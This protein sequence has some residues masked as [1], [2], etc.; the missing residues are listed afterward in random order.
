M[1]T[2]SLWLVAA[3]HAAPRQFRG[4]FATSQAAK[5]LGVI[6][7]QNA[8]NAAATFGPKTKAR[9]LASRAGILSH[10]SGSAMSA[11]TEQDTATRIKKSATL[12]CS[13]IT[14]TGLI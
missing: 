10:I 11:A 5:T 14:Q 8:T 2:K 4:Y 9:R 13:T 3:T 1:A 12:V 6:I 7:R